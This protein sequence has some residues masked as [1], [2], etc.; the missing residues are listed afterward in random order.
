MQ[1]KKVF[2]I[3]GYHYPSE[4]DWK[5][6]IETI[7]QAL[8]SNSVKAR[9]LTIKRAPGRN[10]DDV[11]VKYNSDALIE[12]VGPIDELIK[13]LAGLPNQD[14]IRPFDK[15]LW[16]ISHEII[17]S[18]P[19]GLQRSVATTIS[20]PEVD[21][22]ESKDWIQTRLL[23][24]QVE[25]ALVRAFGQVLLDYGLET[26]VNV[27]TSD[28]KRG[29][30]VSLT[31]NEKQL[32]TLVERF[33]FYLG[34]VNPSGM[35]V[36]PP[37]AVQRNGDQ[38]NL[39]PDSSLVAIAKKRD[40]ILTINVVVFELQVSLE[41]AELLLERFLH[42]GAASKMQI[43]SVAVYDF[44]DVRAQL[45]TLRNQV[46]EALFKSSMTRASLIRTTGASLEA[47]DEALHDLERRGIIQR[48]S[49]NDEYMLVVSA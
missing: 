1:V 42:H 47:L 44:P 25:G 31:G 26:A 16:H 2:N 17:G 29:V 18:K 3:P 41:E 10:W 22:D 5:S 24:G 34:G 32:E 36:D 12:V 14:L 37:L 8:T 33:T 40:G 7:V 4:P 23:R 48:T 46:I 45:G 30:H 38:K 19:T 15:E 13:I 27:S 49:R 20:V 43:G 21:W 35:K 28:H 6:G 9:V 39:P 11:S